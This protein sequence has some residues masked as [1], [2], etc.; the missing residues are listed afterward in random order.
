MIDMH[1]KKQNY[2]LLLI[3]KFKLFEYYHHHHHHHLEVSNYLQSSINTFSQN[4]LYT[5]IT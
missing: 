5:I 3:K 4:F 1:K 2:S